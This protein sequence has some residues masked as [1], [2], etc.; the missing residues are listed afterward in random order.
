MAPAFLIVGATGN[1]GRGVVQTLSEN[2]R[3]SPEFSNHRIIALTRSTSGSSAKA[4]AALPNI[5]VLEYTW[6]EI[7]PDWL[8]EH[9][10]ER[11]F[12]ASHNEPNQFAE[13]AT[14]HHAALRAGVRYV[15]RISTT[16][17]NIRPDCNA[18]YPRTHWAI[19]Q[20]LSS[21]EFSALQWSSLQPNVFPQFVFPP[22]I[23]LVKQYRKDGTQSTLRLMPDEHAKLGIVDPIEVGNFAATLLL[24]PSSSLSKHNKQKY[25]LNGAHDVTGRQI[26]DLVE[27][28]IGTKVEDVKFRDMSFVE[29]MAEQA[30]SKFSKNV[31]MSIQYAAE[32]SWHGEAST[33]TT[34]KEVK[35]IRPFKKGYQQ[36]WRELLDQ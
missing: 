34:S 22:A 17:C 21:P 19:E 25:V 11:A 33:E 28:E 27:K 9:E 23:E 3:S 1:T 31:M 2:I 15:A 24:T 30:K 13:E 8:K 14:F 18:Y 6:T 7:T 29:P 4:L 5:E 32:T 35:D 16:H 12:I 36:F 10:V 20:L 26:V